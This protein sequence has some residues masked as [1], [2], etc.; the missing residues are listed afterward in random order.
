MDES[1][2]QLRNKTDEDCK[3]CYSKNKKRKTTRKVVHYKG[4]AIE[5]KKKKKN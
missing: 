2:K 4:N 3:S 5:I 1:S